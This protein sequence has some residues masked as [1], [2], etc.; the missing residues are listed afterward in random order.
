V[1]FLAAFWA[2]KKAQP[3]ICALL[4]KR[5]L[6]AR[7]S[8]DSHPEGSKDLLGSWKPEPTLTLPIFAASDSLFFTGFWHFTFLAIIC[9]LRSRPRTHCYIQVYEPLWIGETLLAL[10]RD[11]N[12]MEFSLSCFAA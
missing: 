7:N 12:Q 5:V 6:S 9:F 8:R 3:T 4:A 10:N 1:P 11:L 2:G